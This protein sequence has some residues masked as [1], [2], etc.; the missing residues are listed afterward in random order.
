MK[1]VLSAL[2][3]LVA[4]AVLLLV[5]AIGYLWLSYYSEY[6]ALLAEIRKHP[7]LQIVDHWRH[8]DMTLEDFGFTLRGARGEAEIRITDGSA[9]RGPH[10]R[11]R[12]IAFHLPRESHREGNS[13][14][15]IHR[16]IEFDSA[17][18]Q[19][20][21]LPAVRTIAELLPHFDAVAANLLSSPPLTSL[22]GGPPP[23]FII[24]APASGR[25]ISRLPAEPL[26][27]LKF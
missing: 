14:H 11:A 6:N 22:L 16:F 7:G 23:D 24:L 27:K 21:G 17:D 13:V 5:G 18:W 19:Q 4:A 15:P 3:T 25:P 9:I 20:R 8:E 2:A 26:S 12:G 1:G 10:D